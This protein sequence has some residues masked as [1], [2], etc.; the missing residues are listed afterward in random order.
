MNAIITK[1]ELYA[2]LSLDENAR[3]QR[4]FRTLD[5][6]LA[7]YGGAAPYEQKRSR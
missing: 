5:Q 6:K 3:E 4:P 2:A 7:A 1:E